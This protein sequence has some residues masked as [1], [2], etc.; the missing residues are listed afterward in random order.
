VYFF[1]GLILIAVGI[2]F[3]TTHPEDIFVVGAVHVTYYHALFVAGALS[4]G[5]GIWKWVND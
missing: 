5:K 2:R 1:L 3:I 4:I